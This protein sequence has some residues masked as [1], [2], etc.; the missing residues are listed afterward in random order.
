MRKSSVS[1]LT[2]FFKIQYL[3]VK[4]CEKSVSC[5]HYCG[6]GRDITPCEIDIG[7]GL[8]I[9]YKGSIYAVSIFILLKK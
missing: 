4:S 9:S 5:E 8:W 7:T 3:P 6:I 1:K 2:N